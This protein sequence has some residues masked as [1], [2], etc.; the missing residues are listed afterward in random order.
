MRRAGIAALAAGLAAALAGP[1]AEARAEPDGTWYAER[2]S[3]GDAP[4]R[5]EHFWSKGPWLRS[6]TVVAGHPI[7]TLVKGERYLII[8]RLTGK[9]V[10]IQRSAKAVA[11]DR[12]R[13]RPFGNELHVLLASGGEKVGTEK[14]GEASCELYRLTNATGRKEVCVSPEGERL[15]LLLNVWLRASGHSMQSRYLE[16][17][18]EIDVPDTFFEPP[19]GAVLEQLTYEEYVERAPREQLGPAPPLH[20]ELLHGY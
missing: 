14:V 16:W 3:T 13:T 19:A 10:S 18:R 5:V 7:L 1:G 8:D 12:E 9:G 11:E 17:S 2:I 6:E 20:A 4:V 15:P